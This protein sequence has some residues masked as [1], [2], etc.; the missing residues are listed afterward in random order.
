MLKEALGQ[1]DEGIR[2]G[3]HLIKTVRYTDEQATV[4]SSAHGLQL[5]MDKMQETTGEYGMKINVKKTKV[6]KI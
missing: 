2:V 1:V 5:M 4:A 6:M 3:G